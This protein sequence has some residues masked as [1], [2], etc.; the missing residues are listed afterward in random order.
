MS[1]DGAQKRIRR[2]AYLLCLRG[3]WRKNSV[4]NMDFNS[5]RPMQIAPALLIFHSSFEVDKINIG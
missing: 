1:T 2:T 4:K 5:L 3:F